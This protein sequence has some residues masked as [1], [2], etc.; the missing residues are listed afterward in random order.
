M[1]IDVNYESTILH[2]FASEMYQSP[3]LI[4]DKSLYFYTLEKIFF[5]LFPK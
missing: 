3:S 4:F 5:E 1:L 2:C